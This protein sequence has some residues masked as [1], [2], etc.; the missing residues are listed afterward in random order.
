ML[1]LNLAN[2]MWAFPFS[3]L[4]TAIQKKFQMKLAE[5]HQKH[6]LW[7]TIQY[8]EPKRI[9]QQK[10]GSKIF[11]IVSETLIKTWENINMEID[12]KCYE[13]VFSPLFLWNEMVCNNSHIF[14]TE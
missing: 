12:Q 3:A 2:E 6:S 8:W 7:G 4:V 9:G 11:F 10:V 14:F 13:N 1:G 5:K